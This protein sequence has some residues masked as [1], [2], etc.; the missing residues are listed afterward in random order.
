MG[1]NFYK[2]KVYRIQHLGYHSDNKITINFCKEQKNNKLI[3][4]DKQ[5]KT[6]YQTGI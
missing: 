6:K 1:F 5:R 4:K 2:F 3:P